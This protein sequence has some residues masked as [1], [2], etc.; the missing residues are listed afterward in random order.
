[1]IV[2]LDDILVLGRSYRESL[3]N[4]DQVLKLLRQ[5]GF[6][7][8]HK[9][10]SQFHLRY[11]LIWASYGTQ[12]NASFPS[13]GKD[14]RFETNSTANPFQNPDNLSSSHEVLREGKSCGSSH[15][16]G[17]SAFQNFSEPIYFHLQK[18][19]RLFQVVQSFRDG[20]RRS[21]LVGKPK[22]TSCT[23][24]LLEPQAQTVV[25]SDASRAGWDAIHEGVPSSGIWSREVTV[26]HH[27]NE[28]EML[29]GE[30]A[31]HHYCPKI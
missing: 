5:L 9:K 6:Q 21:Y 27:I 4:R 10:S 29:A 19:V 14:S 23:M 22:R 18:S 12:N 11:L 31:L 17:T 8:N 25:E 24:S 26:S 2:F 20:Q 16:R 30:N 28:L 13:I 1:M 15:S 3:Q 7:L